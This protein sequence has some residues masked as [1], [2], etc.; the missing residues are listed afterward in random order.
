MSIEDQ[1]KALG[2]WYA[3][4]ALYVL[5]RAADLAQY[6]GKRWRLILSGATP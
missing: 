2:I 4:S 1:L 3:I 5:R 6:A